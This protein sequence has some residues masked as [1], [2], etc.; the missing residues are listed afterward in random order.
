[1]LPTSTAHQ[2]FSPEYP[3]LLHGASVPPEFSAGL[4]SATPRQSPLPALRTDGKRWYD[5]PA[6]LAIHVGSGLG[7]D[8]GGSCCPT[9]GVDDTALRSQSDAPLLNL[10]AKPALGSDLHRQLAR[11]DDRQQTWPGAGALP[12]YGLEDESGAGGLPAEDDVLEVATSGP[13]PGFLRRQSRAP[14][15]SPSTATVDPFSLSSA[16]AAGAVSLPA[17]A[18]AAAAVAVAA[19]YCI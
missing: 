1:M 11:T 17:E 16:A 9:L 5:D 18:A 13:G 4:A 19:R 7:N 12:G 10:A 3:P 8:G 15:A 2:P 14:L 6:G